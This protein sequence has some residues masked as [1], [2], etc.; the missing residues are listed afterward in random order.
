V[1]VLPIPPAGSPLG[2]FIASPAALGPPSPLLADNLDPETRD[3][4]SLFVGMD[5]IDAQ[6]QVALTILRGS[7]A[8]VVEDGLPT[9]PRKIEQTIQRD[10][11]GLIR[12][13]FARLVA[14]GD[15]RLDAVPVVVEQDT[16]N[17]TANYF[18]LRAL[19][20]SPRSQ[21]VSVIGRHEVG[22]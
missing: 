10:A 3:Y 7:G 5:V 20:A 22:A 4:R 6:V 16:V 1:P 2:F 14:N 11:E 17:V 8:S 21:A 13:A 9:P 19:D 12:R 15:V 18:N